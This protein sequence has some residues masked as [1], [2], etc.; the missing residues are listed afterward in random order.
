VFKI[1]PVLILIFCSGNPWLT[2]LENYDII[3]IVLTI[4]SGTIE[5]LRF[6]NISHY[7]FSL[8]VV[9]LVFMVHTFTL[10][11]YS[12]T[13]YLG[14]ILK[15]WLGVSTVRLVGSSFPY[16]YVRVMF[17][18]ALL[19]LVFFSLT[20]VNVIFEGIAVRSDLNSLIVYNYKFNGHRNSGFFWEPGA[21]AAFLSL[22]LIMSVQQKMTPFYIIV[23][24]ITSIT[25]QSTT[26]AVF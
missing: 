12:I 26:G 9:I 2:N 14:L 22:A 15:I 4:I 25:T 6:N 7:L 5:S 24:V 13:P 8:F 10:N 11:H 17:L 1:I 18:L 19:S 20:F 21:H 16:I 3:L 23:F